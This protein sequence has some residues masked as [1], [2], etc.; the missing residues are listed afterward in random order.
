MGVAAL[1]ETTCGMHGGH[2]TEGRVA[3]RCPQTGPGVSADPQTKEPSMNSYKTV[4]TVGDSGP[5]VS[6]IILDLPEVARAAEVCEDMFSVYVERK[7]LERGCIALAKEHRSD[8]V[9][10]PSRG[11]VP[12]RHAYVCDV[13]GMPTA[14]GTNVALELPE[15]RLTKRIDGDIMRSYVRE[16]TFRVTQ[17][18][19]IPAEVAGEPPV[20]GLVFDECSGDICPQLDGWHLDGTG[21]FAGIEI[22]Y[23]WYEPDVEAVKARRGALANVGFGACEPLPERLPLVVWLHGAGEGQ[24]PY[25]TVTGNKAVALGEQDIQDKLGGA[26]WVLTPSCPTFWMDPDGRGELVDDN[27][28]AYSAA[29]KALI[30]DF[31]AAHGDAIDTSR[32]YVG[33]LSNGGFMTCRLVADN[34]GFFA[35][36]VPVCAPWAG[37]LGTKEE[38]EALAGTPMWW[39]QAD[40]DPLVAPSTHIKSAWPH[41]LAAGAQDLH[42][43]Y[44][45]HIEDETGAYHD[46]DG[47]PN[48][49]IGHLIWINVYHDTIKTDLDGSLVLH[50]G[51]PVTLWQWVGLH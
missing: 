49:Y 38:Y 44:Y 7:D 2:K 3:L 13:A 20:V 12:I 17:T 43:T 21:S 51:F 15:Q 23:A 9:S 34:P 1:F 33:G 47:R 41:L 30:D 42:A 39:V 27:Q 37:A 40:D 48:R 19:A 35:A 26:A 46:E 8:P 10:L 4:T 31:V 36:A 11:Y 32:I 25:R 29:V 24:E 5:W 18:A 50:D 14:A 6:K 45:D 28:S 16:L 22:N